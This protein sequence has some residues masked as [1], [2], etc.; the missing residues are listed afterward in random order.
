[1]ALNQAAQ[2]RVAH[3]VPAL[4]GPSGVTGGAER[5]ALELARAMARVT[6]TRIVT[7]GA[8]ESVET[9]GALDVRTVGPAHYVRG[10][11]TNPFSLRL[12]GALRNVDL[13]HCHQTH[14]ISSSFA[15]LLC[16][17]TGRRVFTTDL[18]GGGWDISGYVSTD[19]WY[20]GHLHISAYSRRIHGHDGKPWAQV[21][22][23]GV[24]AEKF[25]PD[26]RVPR[27]GTV[28]FV[29]RILPHKGLDDL[30]DAVPPD[31]PLDIIG[32]APDAAYL[33]SLRHRAGGKQVSFRIGLADE[34]LV[35]AYRRASCVVLPSVYRTRSGMETRV[36]ELLGQT[37]LEGMACETPG[38][39]TD[40]ASLP[41]VIDHEVSGFVVPPGDPSGLRDRLLWVRAHPE[42]AR[43]MGR[44]ARQRVL[45]H[46]NWPS[47][48]E[49]CLSAYAG[50]L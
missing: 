20:H 28:L 44:R 46:F 23:G 30:I 1:M 47:V 6:P 42:D 14:V 32:P 15:A 36:P 41:E 4:F 17:A 24:D 38:I 22:S 13:V 29:G 3:I 31:V 7:F 25:S 26:A 39:C 50:A 49:R 10:Q 16:R 8:V 45:D 5:Y 35:D 43:A 21:I 48:V 11:R 2:P 34:Q 27:D 33:D 18:G 9:I 12:A 19:R 40:V 37:L